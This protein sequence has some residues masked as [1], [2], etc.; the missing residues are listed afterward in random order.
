MKLRYILRKIAMYIVRSPKNVTKVTIDTIAPHDT[1]KERAVVITGG[2]TGIGFAIAKKIA[3]E[4]ARV[5]IT[6]RN[7]SSLKSACKI[8]GNNVTYIV[9]DVGIVED[10]Y[11]FFKQCAKVLDVTYID[12]VIFNAGISLHEHDILDVTPEGFDQQFNINLRSSYF[13]AQGF[14]KNILERNSTGHI[15]FVS[16]ETGA[17]SID[18]PYG[19]TKVALNSFV[20]GLARRVYQKGIRVNAIAPGVT[21]TNMTK[22]NEL[23]DDY[24]LNNAAG[25]YLLCDEIAEVACFLISNVSSCI[26]GEILYCDAGNHLKINGLDNDYSL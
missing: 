23:N 12:T 7:E 20:G 11:N 8:I 26:T 24:A 2:S 4:G 25:R 22:K 1:L 10:F 19:L 5:L 13:G 15:L 9:S 6:G 16:S 3:S 14:I 21:F 17:K 18:I